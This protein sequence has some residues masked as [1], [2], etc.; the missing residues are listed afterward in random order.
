MED[1]RF[2]MQNENDYRFQIVHMVKNDKFTIGYIN[3]MKLIM[4]E[5]QHYFVVLGGIDEN[6]LI[7]CD[8]IIILKSHK[9]LIYNKDIC[10]LLNHCQKI[11]VTGVFDSEKWMF[12]KNKKILNKTF[13]HFWGGDFYGFRSCKTIKRSIKKRIITSCIKKCASVIFLIEGEYEKFS[14]IMGIKKNYYIAPMPYDPLKEI[15]YKIYRKKKDNEFIRILV[16]N[17]ATESNRHLEIFDKLYNFRE[18][19]IEICALLSYGKDVEYKNKVIAK[20]NEL[21]GYKFKP[22]T[23]YMDIKNYWELLANCDIG[24][25]NNDRQQAMGGIRYMLGMGKKVYLRDDTAMWQ[26]FQNEGFAVFSNQNI[27]NSYDEFISFKTNLKINNENITDN[28]NWTKISKD[29]WEQVLK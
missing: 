29:A 20:G 4:T 25:F 8:N 15:D 12:F 1:S 16:G 27:N 19:N 18:E 9:E 26:L 3:F 2:L 24:I 23:E 5:W 7:N 21:F 14:E 28:Q 22:I 17:S 6:A 13:L 10:K 11:I